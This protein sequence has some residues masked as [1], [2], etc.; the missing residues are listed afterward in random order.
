MTRWRGC[1]AFL[2]RSRSRPRK[3]PTLPNFTPSPTTRGTPVD[4]RE[5]PL[6][7]TLDHDRALDA[8][9]ELQTAAPV[10]PYA[11]TA[12]RAR[13]ILDRA[14]LAPF[15]IVDYLTPLGYFGP[16]LYRAARDFGELVS[17]EYSKAR[18]VRP[19]K[20]ERVDDESGQSRQVCEYLEVDR[21]LIDAAYAAWSEGGQR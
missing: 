18:G 17:A 16:A 12:R 14:D 20:V 9:R 8:L 15:T 10:L 2:T 6:T 1:R 4:E 3:G 11:E 21:P 13:A 5:H 19:L 7:I